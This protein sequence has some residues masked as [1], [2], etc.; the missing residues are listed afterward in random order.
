MKQKKV[1][2][3]YAIVF[4]TILVAFILGLFFD[5]AFAKVIYHPRN[6]FGVIMAA[7]GETP[8]YGGMAFIAGGLFFI[9][10]KSEKRLKIVLL[11]ISILCVLAGTY[12]SMNAIKSH[13]A[14]DIEDMWYVSLPIALFLDGGLAVLGYELTS[15]STNKDILR[16][17]LCMLASIVLILLVVTVLKKIWGRPRYRFLVT[18]EYYIDN[19]Y[20]DWWQIASGVKEEF[21]NISSDNFKSCPSGHTGSASMALLLVYIPCFNE[22][23]K[24]KEMW[25]LL[26][27]AIWAA[28]VGFS[29]HTMGAHFITDT[30]FAYILAMLIIF[31][32]NLVFFKIKNPRKT[33]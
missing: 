6:I 17:L 30:T 23:W 32:T 1:L 16:V 14:L 13:N 31:L 29:R 7:L 18:S 33:E 5:L 9:G 22:K 4:A 12:L 28:L 21:P 25:F 11:I 27:G 26:I 10:R 15:K 24:G 2:I 8:A 20:R 19:Y 3:T